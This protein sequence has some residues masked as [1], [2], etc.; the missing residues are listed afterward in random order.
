[1]WRAE[2]LPRLIVVEQDHADVRVAVDVIQILAH[3]VKG[4]RANQ[5]RKQCV[6]DQQA[7]AKADGEAQR[8]CDD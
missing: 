8:S 1:M 6:N 4:L 5:T 2:M 3:D 7:R